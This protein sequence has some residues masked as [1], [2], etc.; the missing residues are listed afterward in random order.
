MSDHQVLAWA[1]PAL[2]VVAGVVAFL[3][4]SR[5]KG[6]ARAAFVTFFAGFLV[7]LVGAIFAVYLNH[8]EVG[9]T[10]GFVGAL[11]CLIGVAMGLFQAWGSH[12]RSAT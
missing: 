2:A 11:V 4:I 10:V 3:T 6:L 1:V 5:T 9:A 7:A 12:D 8:I